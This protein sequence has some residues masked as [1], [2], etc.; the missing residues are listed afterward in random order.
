MLGSNGDEDAVVYSA[1]DIPG[2]PESR[3]PRPCCVQAMTL[4]KESEGQGLCESIE[5]ALQ[6]ILI[7]AMIDVEV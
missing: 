3:R 7:A 6:E 5:S 2:H 4:E 1:L